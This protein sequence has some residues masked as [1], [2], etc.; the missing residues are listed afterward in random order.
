MLAAELAAARPTPRNKT[1]AQTMYDEN[2]YCFASIAPLQQDAPFMAK[3][4][5]GQGP[6]ALAGPLLYGG[7]YRWH[8][9]TKNPSNT[10]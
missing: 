6:V 9:R 5:D 2:T 4:L 3:R 10:C 8:L 7:S 1:K